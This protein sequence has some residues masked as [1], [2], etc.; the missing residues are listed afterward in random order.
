MYCLTFDEGRVGES[1]LAGRGVTGLAVQV[2]AWQ[3]RGMA[4]LAGG[5]PGSLAEGRLAGGGLA[6]GGTGLAYLAHLAE[7]P[8]RIPPTPPPSQTAVE[9][10]SCRYIYI[11]NRPYVTQCSRGGTIVLYGADLVHCKNEG[12]VSRTLN[13]YERR[14]VGT[15][16]CVVH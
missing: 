13:N 5:W 12:E 6:G 9:K 16:R 2:L 15:S 8:P 7:Y 4:G 1:G 3:G 11:Y 10:F 14:G